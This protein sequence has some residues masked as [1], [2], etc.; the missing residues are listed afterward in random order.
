MDRE[1]PRLH[2]GAPGVGSGPASPPLRTSCKLLGDEPTGPQ[3]EL[4]QTPVG[5]L[6]LA[7]IGRVQAEMITIIWI[8]AQRQFQPLDLGLGVS[9]RIAISRIVEQI[10][11]GQD[12]AIVVHLEDGP[13]GGSGGNKED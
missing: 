11:R 4:E 1:G 8:A 5:L 6:V 9:V 3:I 10:D 2:P 12:V 13:T 7:V